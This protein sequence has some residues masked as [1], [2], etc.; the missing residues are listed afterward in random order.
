MPT[1][2]V[3]ISY[4]GDDFAAVETVKSIDSN[5]NNSIKFVDRSLA[6]PV[7]NANDDV[8]RRPPS[9]PASRAVKDA[10]SPLLKN[11]GKLLV[12]IGSNT[13]SHEWVKWEIDTYRS[14]HPGN[15]SILLMRVPGEYNAGAPSNINIKPI[16]WNINDLKNWIF[17]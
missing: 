3:F 6:E 11:A 2:H 4:A 16:D 17:D 9:D 13:H 8:I 7:R 5:P 14:L 15:R 12:L 10:I 1:P